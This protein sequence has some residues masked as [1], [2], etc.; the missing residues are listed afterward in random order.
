MALDGDLNC[1]AKFALHDLP[2][3]IF[4]GLDFASGAV[5]GRELWYVV[6]CNSTRAV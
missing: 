3:L 1:I 5:V 4:A 6:S 2:A